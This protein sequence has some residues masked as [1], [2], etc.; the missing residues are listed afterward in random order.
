MNE[1]LGF[2]FIRVRDGQ[3][4]LFQT[5]CNFFY[6]YWIVIFSLLISKVYKAIEFFLEE[7]VSIILKS[8]EMVQCL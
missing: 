1:E 8:F 4:R 2:I 5:C 7:W 6:I 3:P